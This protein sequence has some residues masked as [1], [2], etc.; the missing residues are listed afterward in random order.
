MSV[1]IPIAVGIGAAVAWKIIR[2]ML[3]GRCSKCGDKTEPVATFQ[4]CY[5]CHIRYTDGTA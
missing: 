4:V 2:P 1:I 5:K 3:P